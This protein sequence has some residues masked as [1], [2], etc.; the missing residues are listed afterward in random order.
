MWWRGEDR[1]QRLEEEGES[2]GNPEGGESF[3]NPEGGGSFGAVVLPWSPA[4]GASPETTCSPLERW[5]VVCMLSFLEARWQADFESAAR[6]PAKKNR[7]S[8]PNVGNISNLTESSLTPDASLASWSTDHLDGSRLNFS[9]S[10]TASHI[11]A[12][13]NLD[14]A[15]GLVGGGWRV[16]TL[17]VPI[18]SLVVPVGNVVGCVVDGGWLDP[19]RLAAW[20][21]ACDHHH[22][23]VVNYFSRQSNLGNRAFPPT[24]NPPCLRTGPPR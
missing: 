21:L 3:G 12:G 14:A 7:R 23:K 15:L 5:Q 16:G 13:E 4:Q 9:L 10:G 24:C 22:C 11:G 18:G 2:F 1:R 19:A 8:I 20:S 17:V 6:P